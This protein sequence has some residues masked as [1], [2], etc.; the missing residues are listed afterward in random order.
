V[1]VVGGTVF[2]LVVVVL[3]FG[4]CFA[5]DTYYYVANLYYLKKIEVIL[6]LFIFVNAMFFSQPD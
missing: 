5:H 2:D 4:L 3:N 6:K 1:V